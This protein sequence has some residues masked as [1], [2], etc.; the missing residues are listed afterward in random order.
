MDYSRTSY[1]DYQ[2]PLGYDIFGWSI[3]VCEVLCVPVVMIYKIATYKE[4]IPIMQVNLVIRDNQ[5][6]PSTFLFGLS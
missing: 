1:G 4:D 6:Q 5:I 2:F 3:V